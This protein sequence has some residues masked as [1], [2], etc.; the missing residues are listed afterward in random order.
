MRF[1]VGSLLFI[2]L[3]SPTSPLL[4]SALFRSA[5]AAQQ[6]DPVQQAIQT[7]AQA[8]RSWCDQIG[9]ND[10]SWD[11]YLHPSQDQIN[12]VSACATDMSFDWRAVCFEPPTTGDPTFPRFDQPREW[13]PCGIQ[14]ND[15]TATALPVRP[16]QFT[17]IDRYDHIFHFGPDGTAVFGQDQLTA[18]TLGPDQQRNGILAFPPELGM[19]LP[20]LLRWQPDVGPPLAVVI[21]R[22]V[23]VQE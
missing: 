4:G 10:L 21:T 15:R 17:L 12:H 11:L 5:Q 22:L 3:T 19:A 9:V 18:I 2:F 20:V 14:V 23:P 7:D 1:L 13:L 8:G 6:I 16:D